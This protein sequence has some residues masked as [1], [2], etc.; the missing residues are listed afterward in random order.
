MSLI[1][2]GSGYAFKWFKLCGE[3]PVMPKFIFM[4]LTPFPYD[5]GC[6]AWQMPFD[7]RACVDFDKGFMSLIFGMNMGRGMV[8][9]IHANGDSKKARNDRHIQIFIKGYKI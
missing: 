1:I 8:I 3:Y 9:M 6:S 5:I 2:V 7:Y 4:F